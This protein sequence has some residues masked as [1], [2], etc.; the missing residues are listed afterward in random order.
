[1]VVFLHRDHPRDIVEGHGAQAE[2]RVVGDLAHFVD[3]AVQVRCCDA[4]DGGDEVGGR[5]AVMVGRGPA[6]L[7][8]VNRSIF[9]WGW[10]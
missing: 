9:F 10:I 6:T 4:V 8:S 3:E 5:E 7:L 1:M 2:V